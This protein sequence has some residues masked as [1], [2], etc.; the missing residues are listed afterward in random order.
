MKEPGRVRS[1]SMLTSESTSGVQGTVRGLRRKGKIGV[2]S[3]DR[4]PF[5]LQLWGSEKRSYT[6]AEASTLFKDN[7]DVFSVIEP[8]IYEDH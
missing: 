1:G 7:A 3:I 8:G 5:S 2:T 4:R 6:V